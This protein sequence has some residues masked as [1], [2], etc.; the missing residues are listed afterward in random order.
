M[1]MQRL[2]LKEEINVILEDLSNLGYLSTTDQTVDGKI[3][4]LFVMVEAIVRRIDNSDDDL[5]S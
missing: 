2:T 4:R 3:S 5:L 1:S